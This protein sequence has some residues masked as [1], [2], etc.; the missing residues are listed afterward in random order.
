[1][2]AMKALISSVDPAKFGTTGDEEYLPFDL[3][4]V[5]A[6]IAPRALITTDGL[7]DTWANPYGTQITWMAADE[8]YQFLGADGKNAI[9]LREGGHEYKGSDW[10][11]VADFCDWIFY[12]KEPVTSLIPTSYE[13]PDPNNPMAAMTSGRMDWRSERL[14]YGWRRP[15]AE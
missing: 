8:V 3:H 13:K 12:G 5:K 15:G 9:H 6:L 4:T 7:G 10:L 1:M 14:H 11:V 2:E